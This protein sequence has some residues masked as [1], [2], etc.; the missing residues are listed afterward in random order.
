MMKTIGL[1]LLGTCWLGIAGCQ[2]EPEAEGPVAEGLPRNE[3]RPTERRVAEGVLREE[4]E[5][6]ST[7]SPRTPAPEEP[8]TTE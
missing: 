8:V 5:S 4:R 6:E 2:P 3:S 7:T 1:M